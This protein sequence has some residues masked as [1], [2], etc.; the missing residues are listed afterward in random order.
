MSDPT[1]PIFLEIARLCQGLERANQ[2]V[3]EE[4]GQI[5]EAAGMDDFSLTLQVEDG[6]A[7]IAALEG[8]K[9]R[10]RMC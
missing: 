10:T 6:C 4:L 1:S 2:S 9:E 7:R 8:T 5:E 3:D